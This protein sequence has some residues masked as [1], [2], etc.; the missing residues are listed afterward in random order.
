MSEIRIRPVTTTKDRDQFIRF[1]WTIYEGNPYWVPPLWM[2]RRKLMDKKK[3][4]FYQHAD[5]EFFIAERDGA[6]VGRI[7]AIVNHN[8]NKEHNENMGFFGFFECVND[9]H[10]ANALFDTAKSYLKQKGATAM[11]GPANPSVNDEYGLLVEGFN[12]TPTLL[13]P[14]N[15][16]YYPKLIEAYGFKKSKDLYAYL[17]SQDTVYSEKLERVNNL[18]KERNKLT[19]RSLN[20][21]NFDSD[22]GLIKELYNRAWEK[23]WG[24][25]PM[26]GAEIDAMAADLKPVVVPDLIIFA[27]VKGKPIGFALSVPDINIPLK[28]NTKGRLLPGLARLFLHKKEINIVRIIALGVLP[29]YAATGAAGVL[30]Y[31]TAVKAKRLGYRYGEASWVLEDNVR[32]VKA[33][34]MMNGKI[35]KRYRLYEREI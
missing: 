33:A 22:V 3:N 29:E 16:E 32:M 4:P 35:S 1:L 23:N 15:P 19:F 6:M 30:F 10:V 17:L 26:T 11:R 13:M 25:V 18:V 20:M 8:H 21:K 28:Y 9:Q 27:E 31:E 2:D 24:A 14:Y 12:V 7:A 34:D 5:A